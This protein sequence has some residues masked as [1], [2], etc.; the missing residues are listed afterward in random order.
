MDKEKK[1]KKVTRRVSDLYYYVR[2]TMDELHTTL[3][4][5]QLSDEERNI[6]MYQLEILHSVKSI[7]EKRNRY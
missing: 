2:D 1:E 4:T 3:A 5:R 6:I 7:C